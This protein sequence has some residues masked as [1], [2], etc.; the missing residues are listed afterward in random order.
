MMNKM[1]NAAVIGGA[2]MAMGTVAAITA[3][4]VSSRKT[5][6]NKMKKIAKKT[7]KTMDSILDNMM[8]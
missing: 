6:K 2:V 5:T 7:A 1:E 4:V 8:K 3:G